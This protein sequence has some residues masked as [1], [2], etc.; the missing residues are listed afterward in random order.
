MTTSWL[1]SYV[2]IFW[3][4][5]YNKIACYRKMRLSSVVLLAAKPSSPPRSQSWWQSSFKK[6]CCLFAPGN[7]EEGSFRKALLAPCFAL[8]KPVY[9]FQIKSCPVF[10]AGYVSNL[11]WQICEYVCDSY[12]WATACLVHHITPKLWGQ[13]PPLLSLGILLLKKLFC[14]SAW[15]MTDCFF[16][17]TSMRGCQRGCQRAYSSKVMWGRGS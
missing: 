1:Y 6:R 12:T 4:V 14:D 15:T 16:S 13:T 2:W 8:L 7:L 10:S 3:F 17:E 5:H 11:C 9:G